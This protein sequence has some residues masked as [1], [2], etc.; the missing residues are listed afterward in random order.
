MSDWWVTVLVGVFGLCL[1][2][3][4]NVLIYRL[5]ADRAP[6]FWQGRSLCP[7]CKHGLSWADNIPLLS[8]VVLRGKCRYCKK[9][10]SWQYPVVELTMAVAFV[11]G[12]GLTSQLGV[13]GRLGVLG[14]EV[15]L[16]VIFFSDLKYQ[17]IPDEM[18]ATGAAIR[19]I[20]HIS[21]I[22]GLGW[23]IVT[24]LGTA[25]VFVFVFFLTKQKGLGFGDVKLAFLMGLLLGWPKILVALWS[26][27]I[28]GGG[29]A[30]ILLLLKRTTFSARIALG[31]FL[32]IGVAVAALWSERILALAL[33][34]Y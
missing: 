21:N 23:D 28:L 33:L 25:V 30:V 20:S 31:P 19:A 29:V 11:C 17:L 34:S 3:F 6:K 13:L 15:C 27:F 10:I 14:I 26:A 22:R 4:A 9:S 12:W 16:I 7:K 1:G 18:I 8:F 2:S 32:V 24:G 5:N